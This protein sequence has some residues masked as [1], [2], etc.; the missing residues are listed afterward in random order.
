MSKKRSYAKLTENILNVTSSYPKILTEFVQK[1]N[2]N[3]PEYQNSG[4][5]NTFTDFWQNIASDPSKLFQFQENWM[6]NHIKI[7]NNL[8]NR[9][10]GEDGEDIYKADAKDFRFQDPAWE[11]NI[12]FDYLKQT[13]LMTVDWVSNIIKDHSPKDQKE[14]RKVE[15]YTRQIL[16]AISPSN[17]IYTNP[18]VLRE[19]FDSNADNLLS[20]LDKLYKDVIESKTPKITSV[21]LSAFKV[22]ENIATTPGRVINKSEV[23]ELICYYPKTEEVY[24]TPVLI[25]PPCINKFYILDLQEKNSLVNWLL[26]QGYQVYIVSWVNPD[27]SNRNLNFEDYV[28]DVYNNI[29]LALEFSKAPKITAGGY[30]IG[31]TILATTTAYMAGINES[32]KLASTFYLTTLIDFK[33]PGDIGVFIDDEQ[34]KI[35]EAKMARLGYHDSSD[36]SMTFNLLRSNDMIWSNVVNNYMLGKNPTAFDLLY[37]N[38]DATRVPE[39]MHSFYLRNMYL[40]NNLIKP[41]KINISG[42]PINIMEIKTPMYFMAAKDDHIVPW[43]SSYEITKIITKNIRFVVSESGHVGSIVNHPARNKYGIYTNQK[44][45][46]D[47]ENWFN[48]AVYEKKSWWQDLVEWN[49]KF[50]KKK[51]K[52]MTKRKINTESLYNAPGK[53]VMVK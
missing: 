40:E 47:S 41:G 3:Y 29:N 8:T 30:C 51:V 31:G 15:F 24:D 5:I 49:A 6:N 12:Y 16:D 53:Y 25:V 1:I 37:W 50:V 7:V 2:D 22:G 26:E 21:D 46:A 10:Q 36:M 19:I 33:D 39:K 42:V 43:Y 52:A 11:K 28:E 20:G 44:F 35:M 48:N 32:H 13:Y 9:F 18:A 4:T 34:I 17:F 27:K 23:S 14:R 45:V 38:A